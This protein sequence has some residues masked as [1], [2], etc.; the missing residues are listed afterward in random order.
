MRV[1]S[2]FDGISGGRESLEQSNVKVE[3]YYAFEIKKYA[4]EI[5]LKNHPDIIELGDV[6]KANWEDFKGKIDLLIGGSPCQDF[7][8]LNKN[9]KGLEG[10]KSSLF[11]SYLDALKIIKPKYFFLEN[12]YSMGKKN[13]ELLTSLLKEVR[14][15]VVRYYIDSAE[16]G[17]MHR[18]RYYWT[19][20]PLSESKK[21]NAVLSDYLIDKI[22][23]HQVRNRKS[24][25]LYWDW[26]KKVAV[27]IH[28]KAP[29][30][31][32]AG[33]SSNFR[34]EENGK[35]YCVG[36]ITAERLFGFKDNYTEGLSN[37]KRLDVLGDGWCIP[38]INRFFENL[39]K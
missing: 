25:I 39:E 26:S 29:T 6:T 32:K 17:P 22:E 8:S 14:D 28:K 7:S 4:I 11:Y 35:S 2:L 19:N 9:R 24:G 37:S 23:V 27:D 18:R 36:P 21:S 34:F 3:K 31:V 38:T 16:D 10:Q 12:V 15:D 20:I 5:A 30:L 13:A 1:L 33:L